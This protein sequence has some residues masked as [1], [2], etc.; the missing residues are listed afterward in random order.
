MTSPSLHPGRLRA[1]ITLLVIG[2]WVGVAP[3]QM[4]GHRG[5]PMPE[6]VFPE[7]R[8]IL[9]QALQQSPQMMLKN[10]ELAQSEAAR[11]I[12]FSQLLPSL[13]TNIS[14]NLSNAAVSSNTDVKSRSSG[15]IYSA[16]F[17]QPIYRWGTLKAQDEAAKIQLSI[18]RRNYA[19]AYRQLAGTIR[20]Q[21]LGLVAKKVALRNAEA[22]RERAAYLLSLE[23]A[24]LKF[25]RISQSAILVPRLDFEE[26]GLRADRA[27]E[28]LAAAKRYFSR[29]TGL[30]EIS[31]ERIPGQIPEVPFDP[32]VVT[33]MAQR[34]V[35][36]DWEMHPAVVTARDWVRVAELNYKTAKYRLY[37]MFNFGAGISQVNS[38]QASQNSV[39]QVGVLS[40]SVGLTASW[41]IFDG[42]ATKG[43]QISARANQRYYERNLQTQTDLVLDQVRSLEKQIGF[44]YRAVQLAVIRY[45]QAEATAKLLKEELAQGLASQ[46]AL[47]GALAMQEIYTLNLVNNRLDL[48]SRWSE[49]VSTVETDPALKNLPATLK[50][51]VR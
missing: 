30:P 34:F 27:A 24:K 17:S 5:T 21:Y 2:F 18:T 40:H 45:G 44:A 51:N 7:L 25:G 19:D 35:S 14:Y 42:R 46:V 10:I 49:F 47:D 13:G 41:T 29:L 4:E 6:D 36:R 32:A 48:L 37:P 22:A 43:A 39:A 3:G 31:D 11:M 16:S 38:T 50:S 1:G 12:A 8:S 9:E 26:A 28:D 33:E 20:N 15:L 23:E